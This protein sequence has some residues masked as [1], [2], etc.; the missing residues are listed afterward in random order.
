MHSKMKLLIFSDI[1]G[2]FMDQESYSYD[3]LREY[4]F[5]LK[6]NHSIIFNSSKTFSEIEKINNDLKIN[7]PFIVENGACIFFPVD[8]LKKGLPSNF[9]FNYGNY[10]GY[11]IA[12]VKVSFWFEKINLIRKKLNFNFSFFRELSNKK[13]QRITR[14][15]SDRIEDS[16][17]R[18]YSE[19]IFWNDSKPNLDRFI[20]EVKLIGGLVNIGGKFIHITD[21]YDKGVALKKFISLTRKFYD[22]DFLTVSLGDSQ[23]DLSMLEITDYS[24]IIK[25]KKKKNL[26]LVKR[27]KIYYS[28]D[29]AP[30]GWRESIDYVINTEKT[31]F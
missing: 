25:C 10:F 28:H 22:Y 30:K 23:N 3:S 8:F 7:F 11:P 18:L 9:F 17:N 31:N 2:T 26:D 15:K 1:D 29:I 14:L 13:I 19:P 21:G 27:K 24:C 20:Y 6:K 4:V 5:D 16:K 12:K